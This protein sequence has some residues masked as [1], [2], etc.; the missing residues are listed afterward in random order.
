MNADFEAVVICRSVRLKNQ[1][2]AEQHAEDDSLPDRRAP[3]G[4]QVAER[5]LDPKMIVPSVKRIATNKKGETSANPSFMTTN[6]PPQIAVVASSTSSAFFREV[7]PALHPSRIRQRA[8][9]I[10]NRCAPFASCSSLSAATKDNR[11]KSTTRR[12]SRTP[13]AYGRRTSEST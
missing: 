13:A 6:V 8:S 4:A 12:Q 11:G 3:D 5:R 2:Y 1:S 10:W 9:P 7:M